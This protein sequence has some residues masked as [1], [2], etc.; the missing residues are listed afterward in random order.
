[1][2]TDEKQK[3]SA[4]HMTNLY[5]RHKKKKKPSKIREETTDEPVHLRLIYFIFSA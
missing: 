1:M 3:K 2:E 4:L 5:S